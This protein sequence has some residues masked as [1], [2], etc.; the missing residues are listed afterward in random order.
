[1]L[2]TDLYREVKGNPGNHTV[3]G[4]NMSKYLERMCKSNDQLLRL[5]EIVE[6]TARTEIEINPDDVFEKIKAEGK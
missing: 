4:T 3:H 2:Y 6:R 1:M 5:A